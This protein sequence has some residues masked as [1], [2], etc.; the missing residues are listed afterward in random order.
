MFAIGGL[1][2][3]L[4]LG[5]WNAPFEFLAFL[6]SWLWFF[7]KLA[8]LTLVFIWVRGTL[9]R[10]RVDQVTNFSWK[11]M[12]PMAFACILAGALWHYARGD[13]PEWWRE[14]LA[15]LVPLVV[16]TLAYLFM[17]RVSKTGTRFATRTYRYAE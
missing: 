11:F 7:L 5:G 6:P 3:T 17:S 2:V 1:A 10:I 8:V 4:F 14:L 15:W 16:V 13:S 9:P 12:L